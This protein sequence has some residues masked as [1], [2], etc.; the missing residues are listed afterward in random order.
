MHQVFDNH[1][2][3]RTECRSAYLM[4]IYKNLSIEQWARAH[5]IHFLLSMAPAPAKGKSQ[6]RQQ[7]QRRCRLRQL[8]RRLRGLYL[9]RRNQLVAVIL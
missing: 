7:L 9:I 1:K 5:T 3:K 2:I 6:Q 4:P 8:W